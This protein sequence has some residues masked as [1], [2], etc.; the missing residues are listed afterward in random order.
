MN[1]DWEPLTVATNI[2]CNAS[3]RNSDSDW[4]AT[5]RWLVTG[6]LGARAGVRPQLPSV[7]H[8]I[9][10]HAPVGHHGELLLSRSMNLL[11]VVEDLLQR[12]RSATVSRIDATL[13]S[14]SV[15][16]YAT[17]R[18][19]SRTAPHGSPHPAV[20]RSPGTSCTS[21]PPAGRRG[22][23]ARSASPGSAGASGGRSGPCRTSAAARPFCW[24]GST[25]GGNDHK[26]H[27]TAR[28]ITVTAPAPASRTAA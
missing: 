6:V 8:T 22:R 3:R 16:K 19:G 17:Q 7:C 28:L 20:C 21:S 12:E 15:E 4:H 27:R 26:A 2:F 10:F 24:P 25:T 11:D 23:K 1:G 9:R 18:S 13:R 14:G 5:A